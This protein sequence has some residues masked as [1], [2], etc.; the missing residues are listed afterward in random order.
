MAFTDITSTASIRSVLGVSEREL[1]D[2]VLL[3][4]IYTTR[5]TERLYELHPDLFGDFTD[6]AALD[7]RT[8]AQDR[9]FNLVQAF[10]AYHVASQLVGSLEMSSPQT[11]KDSRSEMTRF[12]SPFVSLKK[13]ILE[14]L[15]LLRMRLLTVYHDINPDSPLP[16]ATQRLSVLISPL[17]VNP[18]TG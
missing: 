2:E 3:E 5:L 8:D 15:A 17:A 9:F 1:R 11:I 6:V 16:S 18:V 14:T 10:A 7:P 13:D 4:P 12:D